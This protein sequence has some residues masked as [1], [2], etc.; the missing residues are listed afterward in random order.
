MAFQ[1]TNGP[2]LLVTPVVIPADMLI[3]RSE[4]LHFIY[5][6]ST[7]WRSL[8]ASRK[9]MVNVVISR[10]LKRPPLPL[11]AAPCT[12]LLAGGMLVHGS[13]VR[14]NGTIE[15]INNFPGT[16]KGEGGT[17]GANSHNVGAHTETSIIALDRSYE[18]AS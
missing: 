2:V 17:G 15:F 6:S 8:Y 7:V 3:R 16:G 10:Q 12:H 18:R 5:V 11:L 13:Y 1:A 9:Q 14:M 4:T